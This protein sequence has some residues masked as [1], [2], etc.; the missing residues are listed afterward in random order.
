MTPTARIINDTTLNV[1][2][3]APNDAERFNELVQKIPGWS[4]FIHQAFYLAILRHLMSIGKPPAILV[5]GVYRGLDLAIITDL[6][7]RYFPHNTLTIDGVDLFSAEPCA[8]WPESKRSMSW[9]QAFGCRPPSF[10]AAKS[11]CSHALL[12]KANSID[13][14]REHAGEYDFIYLDTSHDEATVRAEIEAIQQNAKP[15]LI[16]AG[17][18]YTGNGGFECGVSRALD[19]LLPTHTPLFNRLWLAP[20]PLPR[21]PSIAAAD[22]AERGQLTLQA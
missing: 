13:F 2:R 1:V 12:H 7:E 5:C 10:E 6:A 8:D 21:L 19:A 17:D 15:G 16:L 3:S 9:E 22:A 20:C 14:L 18:D 4:Q 11:A